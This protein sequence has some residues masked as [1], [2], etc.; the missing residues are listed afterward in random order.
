MKV[1][2]ILSTPRAEGT[3]N[4]VLDWL[5]T[6]KC[7]QEVFVLNSQPADLTERLKSAAYWYGEE[8][9]FSHGRRKFTDI[10]TGVY[11]VCRDRKPDLVL[12]WPTGFANW[13]CLG[14]RLAGI[15]K[16]LV[17]AGNPPN[18]N[19][20]GDWMS[21]Y[22]MWPLAAVGAKVV[23]CSDYVRGQFASIPLI[24]KSLF[25]TVWNCSRAGQVSQRAK[26]ARE[27]LP[28]GQTGF[29]ALMVATLEAHKDHET[30]FQAI[31]AIRAVFPDFRLRLAGEGSLR[32]NLVVRAAELG[33]TGAVDFLGTR[34]DVPELLGQADLFV[35][36]TTPQE[37]LGSVLLEAMAA[38][39]PIV[40]SDVP[41]C[42]E[43]LAKGR[44]GTLIPPADAALLAK[45][46]LEAIKT[47]RNAEGL[48]EAREFALSFTAQRMMDQYFQI[49]NLPVGQ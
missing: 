10:A 49:A 6:G 7:E 18:R 9:Y 23:C 38:E 29:T 26:N 21:R 20:R 1:L 8:D 32:T 4:L 41:A 40:A 47:P 37:G 44:Y 28:T 34:N 25:H 22:G 35:L 48:A 24:P 43:V 11:R 45:A 27:A 13:A 42:L 16:L 31:P 46:I 3:P 5:A 12:C 17:H 30:L 15:K 2:H 14:A 33:I 39:I 19:C 36:S